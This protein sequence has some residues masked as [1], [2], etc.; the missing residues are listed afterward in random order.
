MPA[1]SG[2]V[3]TSAFANGDTGSQLEIIQ[4]FFEES[5]NP[6]HIDAPCSTRDNRAL[7]TASLGHLSVVKYLLEKQRAS[8]NGVR[9]P[10]TSLSTPLYNAVKGRHLEVAFYLGKYSPTSPLLS[11]PTHSLTLSVLSGEQGADAHNSPDWFQMF[12]M[13]NR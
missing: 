6:P 12:G 13:P 9:T 7:L 5:P 11:T 8:I 1:L 2:P 4:Y 10:T 3:S